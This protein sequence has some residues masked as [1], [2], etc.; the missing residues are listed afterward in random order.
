VLGWALL[1]YLA[2]GLYLAPAM[3]TSVYDPFEILGIRSS[4]TDKEIKKH[5]K[6]LSLQ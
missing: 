4:A 2:Y 1:A 5:Y 6:K 3:E